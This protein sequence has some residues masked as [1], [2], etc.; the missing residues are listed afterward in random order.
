MATYIVLTSFTN[1]GIRKVK[2]TT[3]RAD[4]L[5]ALANKSNPGAAPVPLSARRR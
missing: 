2:D 4:A 3:K 1:Q 5:Q